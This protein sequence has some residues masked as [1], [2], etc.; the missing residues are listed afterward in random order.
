VDL[1]HGLFTYLFVIVDWRKEHTGR[2][3]RRQ[4]WS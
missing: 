2:K 4:W 3:H 1:V